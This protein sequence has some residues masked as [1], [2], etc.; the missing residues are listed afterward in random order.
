MQPHTVNNKHKDL[1]QYVDGNLRKIQ[2]GADL[3]HWTIIFG[4]VTQHLRGHQFYSK[5][6]IQEPTLCHDN[7]KILAKM[8]QAYKSAVGLCQKIMTPQ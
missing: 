2:H 4:P 7:C 3:A 1:L 5:R 8:R 6:R